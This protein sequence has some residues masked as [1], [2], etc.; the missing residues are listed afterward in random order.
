MTKRSVFGVDV[1]ET[2]A[3]PQSEQQTDRP[4]GATHTEQAG[5]PLS[6]GQVRALMSS[7]N[8]VRVAQRDQP[9]GGRKMSYLEAWDVKAALIRVFGFGGFSAEATECEIVSIEG[10]VP[11]TRWVDRKKVDVPIEFDPDGRVKYGTA[12]FRVTA[13][14]RVTLTIHVLGATYT[15]WAASS[16][17]GSDLGEVTDFA[18]KTAESDALKRAATY[19]GTQF[20]LSLYN[21]GSKQDVVRVLLDPT[22]AALWHDEMAAAANPDASS[23]IQRA[24][25]DI[26]PVEPPEPE[27]QE[28]QQ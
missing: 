22:Q 6:G 23:Q 8:P 17:T 27:A 12:N 24:L 2:T 1:D 11:K 28:A 26:P 15:E 25:A 14:V 16:Q 9:G 7:L 21:N 19:L 3:T 20:G 10:N 13:R 5:G 4:D 18:I